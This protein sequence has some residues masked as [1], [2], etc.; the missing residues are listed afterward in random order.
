MGNWRLG[1]LC[2]ILAAACG[3]QT[4]Q[5]RPEA[6]SGAAGTHSDTGHAGSEFAGG[7]AAPSDLPA[8]SNELPASTC[9]VAS[10]TCSFSPA[11]LSDTPVE[12]R[13]GT[14]EAS[15]QLAAACPPTAC[16]DAMFQLDDLG[17]A[18]PAPDNVESEFSACVLKV[19]ERF[20]W[21]CAANQR[22]RVYKSCTTK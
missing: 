22:V 10:R 12:R 8:S 13:W 2:G 20:R 4:A 5:E 19:F 1:F 9:S 6:A 21:P 7:S 14:L 11:D 3:G 17:C 15:D 16:G 18:T